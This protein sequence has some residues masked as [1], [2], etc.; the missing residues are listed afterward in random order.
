MI[1]TLI[2]EGVGCTGSTLIPFLL[3]ENFKVNVNDSF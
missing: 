3:E 1:K 2:I